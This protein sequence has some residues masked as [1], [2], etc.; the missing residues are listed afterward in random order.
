MRDEIEIVTRPWTSVCREAGG[1]AEGNRT[2]DLDIGNVVVASFPLLPQLFP[3]FLFPLNQCVI[4]FTMPF[5]L[6]WSLA[7]A[8]F[9]VLPRCFRKELEGNGDG[10]ID[11]EDG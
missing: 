6:W 8:C 11:E 5:S 4:G 3:S 10:Q 1:G 2:P 7:A 9:R